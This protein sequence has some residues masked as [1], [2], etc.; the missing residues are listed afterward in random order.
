MRNRLQ[1]VLGEYYAKDGDQHP[2]AAGITKHRANA[3]RKYGIT[4]QQLG[5]FEVA[6]LHVATTNTIPTL[7]WFL[8]YIFT[9]PDLVERLHEE[10]K[11]AVEPRA[12]GEFTINVDNLDAKCPLLVSCYRETIRMSNKPIGNRRVMRDT[13]ISDGNGRSYLLKEGINLQISGDTLHHMEMVWGPD[14]MEFDPE[15]F[16]NQIKGV[17]SEAVKTQRAWW[18]PFGGGKHL[19]PGRNFA[20]AE[21]MGL[22]VTLILGYRV[23]PLDGIWENFKAPEQQQV[24]MAAGVNQPVNGGEGFGVW[25][26]RREGWESARWRFTSGGN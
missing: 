13:T 10:A 26:K 3:L 8:T 7:F 24:G 16:L 4:G 18:V 11:A 12:D 25:I 14:A 20:T 21:N 17:K 19:C 6:L 9:R 1:S 2:D 22:L 15:R 23:Q 5:T